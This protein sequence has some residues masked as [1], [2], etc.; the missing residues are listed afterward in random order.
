MCCSP[1]PEAAQEEYLPIMKTYMERM[2]E[3]FTPVVILRTMESTDNMGNKI[4][5]LPPYHDY[6]LKIKLHDWEMGESEEYC[7]WILE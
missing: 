1:D 5:G 4:L 6:S 7:A 3:W 2:W